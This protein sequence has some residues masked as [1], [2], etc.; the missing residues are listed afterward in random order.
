VLLVH[1]LLREHDRAALE[2]VDTGSVR[3]RVVTAGGLAAAVS[4]APDSG[5]TADDAVAHLDLLVALAADVPVL[6]LPLGTT[7]PDDDAVR[8]EV[9]TP[10]ADQLEEQLAA[11]ADLLELRVD[12]TFDTDAVV[13]D[14]AR[15]DA[16][17]ERLAARSRAPGA[18]FGERMALG[19]AVAGRVAEIEDALTAEWTAELE[20]LAERSAVL[21]A[22]EQGRR[23]AWC[24][25]RERLADA[26]AAVARMQEAA[27]GRAEVE[28]VGPLPVYS[29]L[30]DLPSGP[31]P[32]PRSRWGW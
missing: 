18:G 12:L 20:E 15:G 17:I 13:A 16:E 27:A 31:E 11:I 25:R 10:A 14:I 32:E 28:Y 4:D 1:G 24:V 7:A 30:D 26:D 9:L 21:S 2:R 23:T 22:D 5:L 3:P 29:F 8:E 6:P 19:E